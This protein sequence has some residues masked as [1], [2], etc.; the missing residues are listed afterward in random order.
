MVSELPHGVSTSSVPYGK[1]Y[2]I[3]VAKE[4]LF[5]TFLPP[6]ISQGKNDVRVP[7]G[8]RLRSNSRIQHHLTPSRH[9]DSDK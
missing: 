2:Y 5:E 3:R 7:P 6:P 8:Y 9:R 1:F 4:M